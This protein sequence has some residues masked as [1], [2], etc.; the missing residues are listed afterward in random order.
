MGQ[1]VAYQR[2]PANKR[3]EQRR[4]D[5]QKVAKLIPPWRVEVISNIIK[6]QGAK[7]NFKIRSHG[8]LKNV[9]LSDKLWRCVLKPKILYGQ[10]II[11]YDKAW[12]KQVES[13]Q[14]QVG[15]KI[16]GTCTSTNRTGVRFELG[17]KSIEGEIMAAKIRY[18]GKIESMEEHRLPK[19]ILR[20]IF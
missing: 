13:A 9:D 5:R 1:V 18:S 17:Q 8:L 14:H 20:D 16:L 6:T 19:I 12:L 2:N 11:V 3:T 4:T 10:E 7:N 15:C